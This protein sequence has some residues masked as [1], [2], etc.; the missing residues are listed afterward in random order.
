M[1]LQFSIFM[2]V[3]GG[4]GYLLI[5]CWEYS[6]ERNETADV[7][8]DDSEWKLTDLPLSEFLADFWFG[9]KYSD[10]FYPILNFSSSNDR[11][12]TIYNGAAGR[13]SFR[14]GI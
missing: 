3:V 8:Y 10:C 6:N 5:K 4:I 1:K 14:S 2:L 11:C 12:T 13:L 9:E 7:I